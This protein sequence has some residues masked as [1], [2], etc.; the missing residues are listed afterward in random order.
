MARFAEKTAVPVEETILEIRKTVARYG[1]EQYA[2]ARMQ[3]EAQLDILACTQRQL[4]RI[5]ALPAKDRDSRDVEAAKLAA[6]ILTAQGVVN[7]QVPVLTGFSLG[8]LARATG[9]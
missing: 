6:R 9:L 3:L 4:A 8:D 2:N 1:G 5:D 7:H